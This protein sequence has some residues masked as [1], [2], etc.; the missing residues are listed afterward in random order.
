MDLVLLC[1]CRFLFRFYVYIYVYDADIYIFIFYFKI[2]CIISCTFTNGKLIL[3]LY[4]SDKGPM[5]IHKRRPQDFALFWPPPP[6]LQVSAWSLS[7]SPRFL[8]FAYINQNLYCCISIW[9]VYIIQI[10]CY[11]FSNLVSNFVY[12]Y[13]WKWKLPSLLFTDKVIHIVSFYNN[14][15]L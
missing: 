9:Y 5:A 1:V 8:T 10:A 13:S 12:V 14:N 11:I 3:G 4:L 6:C 7:L 2:L 15:I